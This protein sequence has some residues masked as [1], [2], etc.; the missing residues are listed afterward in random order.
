VTSPVASSANISDLSIRG[1]GSLAGRFAP[2]SLRAA[3][4]ILFSLITPKRS[5]SAEGPKARIAPPPDF[6]WSPRRGVNAVLRR[7]PADAAH[8]R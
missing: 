1:G 3:Y 5:L 4:S 6:P 7:T 2:V 8:Y